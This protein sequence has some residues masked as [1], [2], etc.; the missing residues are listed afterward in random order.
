MEN[1]DRQIQLPAFDENEWMRLIFLLSDTQHWVN[2]LAMN[3]CMMVPVKEKKKLFRKTFYLS[4]TALAHI[5]ERHYY[6]IPRHP[7]KGK[8]TVSVT[9]MLSC[10]R[11]ASTA[12]AVPVPGTLHFYRTQDTGKM[13]GINSDKL[14]TSLVTVITDA[15]G[16]IITAFPGSFKD[17]L[18]N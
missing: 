4:I 13:T 7:E 8:F 1:A 9:D 5:L 16:R 18:R 2:E 14:P 15:G 6:K 11:D 17:K 3:A 12:V 10:I